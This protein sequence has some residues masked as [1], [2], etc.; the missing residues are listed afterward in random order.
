M[1]Y[2]QVLEKR[3]LGAKGGLDNSRLEI[4]LAGGEFPKIFQ[5]SQAE[6]MALPDWKKE[7]AKRKAKLY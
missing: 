2:E 7:V 5:M 1:T 6:F 3:G 4:Y